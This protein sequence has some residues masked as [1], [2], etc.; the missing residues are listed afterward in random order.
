MTENSDALTQVQRF[1]D[2]QLQFEDLTRQIHALLR[3]NKG[4]TEGMSS[5]DLSRYRELARER[6]SVD[7]ELRFL[8][9]Q[10]FGDYDET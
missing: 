6:D 4:G 3:A 7:N 10:L 9:Q 5:A 2:L 1:R 8:Q